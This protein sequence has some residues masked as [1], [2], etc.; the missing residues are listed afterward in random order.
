MKMREH[1]IAGDE[2]FPLETYLL[3]PS[4]PGL[5]PTRRIIFV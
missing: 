4:K 1:V 3:G 5:I 2:T